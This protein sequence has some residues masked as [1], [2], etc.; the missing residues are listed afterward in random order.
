MMELMIT[1]ITDSNSGNKLGAIYPAA[2]ADYQDLYLDNFIKTSIAS[3]EAKLNG[4]KP[5]VV[6]Q[7]DVKACVKRVAPLPISGGNIN[8]DYCT[9]GTVP[10]PVTNNDTTPPQITNMTVTPLS[11][12]IK[13][14]EKVT[15]VVTYN[16]ILLISGSP[17]IA[18][19]VGGV[20]RYAD[21]TTNSPTTM[22]FEYTA[23]AGD[24]D[25]DGITFDSTSIS[26]NGGVISDLSGNNASL[27]FV[28]V[29]PDLSS[30]NVDTVPPAA[31][32]NVVFT[33]PW[34]S[35]TDNIQQASWTNPVADFDHAEVGVGSSGSGTANAVAF[36]TSSGSNN[37]TFPDITPALIECSQEYEVVVR[38]VDGAGLFSTVAVSPSKFKVDKTAPTTPIISL[39]GTSSDVF[40]AP[41]VSWAISSDTCQ[42]DHYELAIGKDDD[43]DGFDPGDVDNVMAWTEV[44]G[45]IGVSSY[46]AQSG[47]DGFIFTLNATDNF[48]VSVRAVDAAGNA[49][50]ES[51]TPDFTV[52]I[53]GP[54]TPGSLAIAANWITGSMPISSPQVS[55]TNPTDPDFQ[56]IKVALGSTIG[57]EDVSAPQNVGTFTNYT[58]TG[59][60]GLNECDKIYPKVTAFDDTAN[61]SIPATHPNV[62][63]ALDNTAPTLSGDIDISAGGEDLATNTAPFADLAPA[64]RSDNCAAIDHFDIAIGWD[65]DSDGFD[66]GDI[67]NTLAFTEIPGGNGVTAYQAVN[68]NDGMFFV[69]QAGRD[70]YVSLRVVDEAGNISPVVTSSAN[71]SFVLD[72]TPPDV[73]ISSSALNPNTASPFPITITFTEDVT[74]FDVSDI[75]VT[76][77]VAG[78]FAGGPAVYTADITPNDFGR[79]YVDINAGVAQD[80]SS[81]PNNAAPQFSLVH[82]S[83]DTFRSIWNMTAG[84]FTLPLRS[85]QTYDF[86]IDWGDGSALSEITAHND[87]DLTHN[88]AAGGTYTITCTGKMGAFY[89]NNNASVRDK[90]TTVISL[91]NMGW[92]NLDSAFEGASNLLS[93]SGGVVDNVTD[94][95]QMFRN[96]TNMSSINVASWDTGNVI[97]MYLMFENAYLAQSRC[98]ELGRFKSN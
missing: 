75:S 86:F 10:V 4:L 20:T 16:E 58:W 95:E 21:F 24:N 9:T 28:A 61:P 51:N 17:R 38:A 93:F 56:H 15:F 77:G 82:A 66:A 74:G 14:A 43:S 27:N 41:E 18:L 96:A 1:Y 6:Y 23:Q 50:T 92:V 83:S 2:P 5:S 8:V 35:S 33:K 46:I 65:D 19:N 69:M 72:N 80:G 76:N 30:I 7:A 62:W 63:F 73:A 54:A 64:F 78:N 25:L 67:D 57:A 12:V 53:A 26:L 68:G 85:G 97:D 29:T 45:G 71:F 47:T 81:N 87:P 59:L 91:G 94:M 98:F 22:T 88:Y 40:V 11:G 52:D 13:L 31:P 84:N 32:T 34:L 37:H 70:Y 39:D 55:W 36:V 49:S 89:I 79:V 3:V 44:P 42:L 48:R 90:I 60:T